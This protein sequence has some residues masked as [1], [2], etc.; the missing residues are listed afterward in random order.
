MHL[1]AHPA[2]AERSAAPPIGDHSTVGQHPQGDHEREMIMVDLP[3]AHAD[4]RPPSEGCSYHPPASRGSTLAA[5]TRQ[6]TIKIR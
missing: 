3:V 4:R 5:A 2:C 1:S 6:P